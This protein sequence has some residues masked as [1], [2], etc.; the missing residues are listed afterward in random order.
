MSKQPLP[1]TS[2]GEPNR[3]RS[4]FWFA[5]DP[6]EVVANS[7]K[8]GQLASGRV[9][10]TKQNTSSLSSSMIAAQAEP[11]SQLEDQ[12]LQ[13]DDLNST[14]VQVDITPDILSEKSKQ[15]KKTNTTSV[16]IYAHLYAIMMFL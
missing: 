2:T 15:K 14:D 6:S 13:L 9:K 11:L 5:C 16:S 8:V 10:Q 7:T 1:T 12:P 4:S 3:K